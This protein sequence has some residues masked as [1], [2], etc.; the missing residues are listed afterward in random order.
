[1]YYNFCTVYA[2]SSINSL[3]RILEARNQLGRF[4]ETDG[5][6]KICFK[7]FGVQKLHKRR[8][9]YPD[10]HTDPLPLAIPHSH[11]DHCVWSTLHRMGINTKIPSV[12]KFYE[13]AYSW[14]EARITR[15]ILSFQSKKK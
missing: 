10:T 7:V 3:L 8:T 1:M 14:I 12:N 5:E 6:S 2:I 15:K 13:K 4:R 11:T 9:Y